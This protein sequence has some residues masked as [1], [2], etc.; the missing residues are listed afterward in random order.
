[1]A[2]IG[3][4]KARTTHWLKDNRDALPSLI[5][6]TAVAMFWVVGAIGGIRF[7]SDA[8]SPMAML[9]GLY[10]GLAAV[11]VSIIIATLALND[12]VRRYAQA[13]NRSEG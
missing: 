5:A 9:T 12:L 3:I 2:L 4:E 6:L 13:R 8:S 10:I 7:L 11:A 1:M